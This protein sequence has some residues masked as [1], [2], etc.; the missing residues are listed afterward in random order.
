MNADHADSTVAMLQHY[1]GLKVEKA[2]IKSLDRSVWFLISV[3]M[4][5]LRML[6]LMCGVHAGWA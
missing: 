6:W 2:S 1:A 3:T 4:G 5:L